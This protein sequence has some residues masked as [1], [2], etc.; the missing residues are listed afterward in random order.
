M[1]PDPSI[2]AIVREPVDLETIQ[3]NPETIQK[4]MQK[5]AKTIQKA[6]EERET[7]GRKEKW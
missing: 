5:D 3:K 2:S 7:K 4:T 1:T 6:F